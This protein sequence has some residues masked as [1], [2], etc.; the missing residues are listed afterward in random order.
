MQEVDDLDFWLSQSDAP[1]TASATTAEPT[2]DQKS[3]EDGVEVVVKNEEV[4]SKSRHKRGKKEKRDKKKN[5]KRSEVQEDPVVEEKQ[6]E[7][8]AVDE[9]EPVVNIH[10]TVYL[11]FYGIHH[12]IN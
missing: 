8:E 10:T 3:K 12:L 4:V 7:A 11:M 6:E 9:P 1:V 5:L 2:V